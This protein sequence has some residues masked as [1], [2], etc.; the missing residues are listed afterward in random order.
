MTTDK[1]AI[2]IVGANGA[3]KS[4][5][6]AWIEQQNFEKVHRIGAQR[7]LNFQKNLQLR[8]FS[9]A[10]DLVQYGTID[11]NAKKQK[12]VLWNW[13]KSYTTKLIQDF[14]NVLAAL[15]ALNSNKNQEF[16]TACQKADAE[17]KQYP[18]SC[19]P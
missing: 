19:F 10:E 4:K 6:G 5:L 17:G 14:D 15:L 3:G 1:N 7:D 12:L 9:E 8:N 13:G 11:E 16:I 2:I 18:R